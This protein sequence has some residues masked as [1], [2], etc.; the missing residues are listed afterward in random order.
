MLIV[1]PTRQN[2]TDSYIQISGMFTEAAHDVEE[3]K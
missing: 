1:G 3:T 2:V